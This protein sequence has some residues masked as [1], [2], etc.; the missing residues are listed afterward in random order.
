[1]LNEAHELIVELGGES[2]IE[3]FH[4]LF[5][6]GRQGFAK[7]ELNDSDTDMRPL[8][9]SIVQYI[10]GPRIGQVDK[11]QVQVANL[12]PSAGVPLEAEIEVRVTIE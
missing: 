8:L 12:Q 3:D 11:L 6:S 7:R 5:M 2:F 10:P 1:M 4:Y 9:D